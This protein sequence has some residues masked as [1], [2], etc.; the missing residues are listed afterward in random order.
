MIVRLALSLALVVLGTGVV[1]GDGISSR[2]PA[3]PDRVATVEVDPAEG[4][5]D[6]V[7]V[8]EVEIVLPAVD[9]GGDVVES[10]AVLEART[11]P[12]VLVADAVVAAPGVTGDDRVVSEVL[13]T[14]GFQTL[15][16]TWPADAAVADLQ[17]QVRT[18]AGDQWSTWQALEPADDAPDAGTADAEAGVR[19][20]TDAL[21]VGEA[22]AVQL[23]FAAGQQEG[24]DGLELTIVDV[25]EVAPADAEGAV[26]TGAATIT[27]ASYTTGPLVA[28]VAPRVI[29]RAQ[30]G[31]RAQVCTPDVASRL[32]GA[33]LHHTAGTNTYATVEQAMQQI[34]GDQA[35]HIDGRGWCDLGYNFVVDKWGNIYEGR[36][37]SLTQPVIGVHAGG[38]NTGTVGV[39]MLGTYDALP[40][41]AAIQAVAQIVG[42]RLGAYGLNP[43]STMS[44]YTYGGENSKV[45]AGT[46][47][48]LPRVFG[49]RDVAFTACPGN[50]G[51]AA[52]P[53][54]RAQAASF[55]VDERFRQAN[56]VVKA[57]YADLL[58]REVDAGGLTSWSGLLASGAGGPALVDALTSSEEYIK[59]RITQAYEEVLGRAPE[60]E[61]LTYWYER[62]R[63]KTA[64]VDDVKRR[65]YDSD[66][67]FQRAGGTAE[68]YVTLLYQTMFERAASARE[69]SSWSAQIAVIGR[70]KVVDGIWYSYEAALYRAAG[71]Y[72]V[73]LQ[74]EPD[75]AGQAG[76]A[77]N[78]LT[79]GEGAV[80]IGIAGSEEYR[81]LA[82]TRFAV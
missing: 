1:P 30:W 5:T 40:S 29:T 41:P 6:D 7:V 60:P 55:S 25:P 68:G 53:S 34:R 18:R 15:G 12:S 9:A 37:N 39:S 4:A 45:P 74:R 43:E 3:L 24:P 64:T 44:Y 23:S 61:G 13:E 36:A 62:I 2:A 66:E 78:L 81:L 22:D 71:Y 42:W 17:A 67:Y 16:V 76:W 63:S 52:L 56:A 32:V 59:L 28:A 33:V 72:R 21:W 58:G 26:A 35:Y 69:A 19:G 10:A 50:G 49:H 65:F 14:A 73:F 79:A 51:Y 46:T 70:S 75:A 57:M 27:T 47:L 54:I 77:R 31:A 82:L 80:R 20:G 11:D 38:F 48:T 8:T